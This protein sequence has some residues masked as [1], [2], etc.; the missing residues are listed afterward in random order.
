MKETC[1]PANWAIAF[2]DDLLSRIEAGKSFKCEERPP[3]S[4]EVGVVKVSAVTW[5]EYQEAESKTCT[6]QSR[7]NSTLFIQKGDF[8]FSRANTIELVGACVIAEQAS[9]RIMLSDKILRLHFADEHYKRWVLHFLRSHSGRT[10]IEL[11]SSGNQDSMRNIGQQR[12]SLIQIPIPPKS[13]KDRIVEKLEE[14]LSDLDAGV[15]ELK[16]AQRKLVRYHQ[17]LLK[18]A[19]EG[20]LTADWRTARAQIG[21]QQETGAELLQRILTERRARWEAKQLAK[22]AEQSKVPPKAWQSKYP[23]P[24]TPETSGLPILPEGWV[25]ASVE[26]LGEVQLGRQRSPDKMSGL[27]PVKYIRAANITEQGVDFND[28]LEMDFSADEILTFKLNAGDVLLT[29]ASGSP[30]HVGRPV[31]WPNVTGVFCFQNTV[32][33]FTPRAVSPD[34]AFCI[35]QAWQKLGIFQKLSGG[36][37][38]NHLSAGKFSAIPVPLP[39]RSEQAAM[40]GAITTALELVYRQELAIK[41]SLMQSNAQ[42]KNILKAAF[43]GQLVPQDPNDEPASMLLERIRAER[44]A[45]DAKRAGKTTRKTKE[46]I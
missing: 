27:C 7:I 15:A 10:Q 24:I 32:I 4:T 35:F 17:S 36:V 41:Q 16:A 37:G 46:R 31:I 21:E 11:L 14:L 44:V 1:L 34:Y 20:T 30:H 23:A 43:A 45:A 6:E 38:I 12:I 42:R 22:F 2:L 8:L 18:A 28:V 9:Q 29:E 13:E 5:G 3:A 40:V 39:P 25:W 19:V 26:Q 33:R